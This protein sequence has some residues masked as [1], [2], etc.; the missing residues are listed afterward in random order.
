MLIL[1]LYPLLTGL[2]ELAYVL[3]VSFTHDFVWLW[4]V[5]YEGCYVVKTYCK[6]L[7]QF[8]ITEE[9]G[10]ATQTYA[11]LLV[12]DLTGYEFSFFTQMR[13]KFAVLFDYVVSLVTW[14]FVLNQL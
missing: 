6:L 13:E 2:F 3:L 14:E 7:K 12:I 11:S 4:L 8:S 10:S 1:I 9:T 5:L